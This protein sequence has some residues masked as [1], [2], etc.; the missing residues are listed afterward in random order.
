MT[1]EQL[2]TGNAMM[3]LLKDKKKQLHT[4]E[5]FLKDETEKGYVKALQLQAYQS[6]NGGKE[7]FQFNIRFEYQDILQVTLV[8]IKDLLIKDVEILQN[9]FNKL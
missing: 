9:E 6:R 1:S 5:L 7:A 3:A 4:I 2:E 8:N